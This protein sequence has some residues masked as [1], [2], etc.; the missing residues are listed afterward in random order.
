VGAADSA[1]PAGLRGPQAFDLRRAFAQDAGRFAAFSLEAPPL[2]ADL[3]KNL[4]DRTAQRLL[5]CWRASA[6]S[7][8]TATPCCAAS[9]STSA[10]TGRSP[11]CI[12]VPNQIRP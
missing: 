8:P 7:R 12:G 3:S 1:L 4:I 2:F 10:K 9:A 5:T 6:A 11:T